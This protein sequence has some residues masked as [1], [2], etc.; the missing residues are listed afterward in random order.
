MPFRRKILEAGGKE[1]ARYWGKVV[2]GTGMRA[3]SEFRATRAKT[4]LELPLFGQ[5]DDGGFQKSPKMLMQLTGC[6]RP[7]LR[8]VVV[9]LYPASHVFH[10]CPIR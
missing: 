5:I 4:R 8:V 2:R 10:M 7:S 9:V 3:N 1:T 6:F